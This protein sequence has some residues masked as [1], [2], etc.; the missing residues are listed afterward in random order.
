MSFDTNLPDQ[1]NALDT[2]GLPVPDVSPLLA[3]KGVVGVSNV[4]GS[5]SGSNAMSFV[6]DVDSNF[7]IPVDSTL[8]LWSGKGLPFGENL[9][10]DTTD[11]L[12]VDADSLDLLG[13]STGVSTGSFISDSTALLHDP[14][15]AFGR[16]LS[17]SPIVAEALAQ[18]E[19]R[20]AT[21]LSDDGAAQKLS[22]IFDQASVENV[23]R[24]LQNIAAGTDA[25]FPE[26]KFSSSESLKNLAGEYSHGAYIQET[27]VILI[28]DYFLY[29]QQALTSDF[30]VS[31]LLEE[32]GH[33]VDAQV[34]QQ[35][36]SGDE[37]ALLAAAAL[38]IS[39]SA[40]DLLTLGTEN[41]IATMMVDGVLRSVE[42][43]QVA[44]T[45]LNG[46]LYRTHR[47][48]DNNVYIQSSS[49]GKD[50]DDWQLVSSRG[51]KTE[52]APD[53][54]AHNGK[55]YISHTGLQD[56]IFVGSIDPGEVD[57]SGTVRVLNQKLG[58]ETPDAISL[59]KFGNKLY[60]FH[61]GSDDEIYYKS[62][63]QESWNRL[64]TPEGSTST[65]DA[66]AIEA[67][68]GKLYV[69]H[70]SAEGEMYFGTLSRSHRFSGWTKVNGS[71]EQAVAIASHKGRLYASHTGTDGQ[72]YNGVYT[73]QKRIAWKKQSRYTPGEASLESFKRKLIES[74]HSEL[75]HIYTFSS[76]GGGADKAAGIANSRWLKED[77][78]TDA[79][80]PVDP[81]PAD[82]LPVDPSPVDPSPV[83]P[84]PVDPLPVVVSP[85]AETQSEITRT[86]FSGTV[87]PN[88][89]VNLRNSPNL[90]DRSSR[91]E[92]K[93]KR[94]QFD[95]WTTGEAVTDLW[96]GK[97]DS[98]W[99]RVK[100]TDLW[101]P[102]GYI[103][104]NPG[105]SSPITNVPSMP[106][107][108]SVTL[109]SFS[110]TVGPNIGVNLRNSPN[111]QDRSSRNE[112][113]SKRLQFDAWT[114]G[115]AVTD[116]WTGKRDS[117]WFRVKGTDLW[118]PSGY[119]YGNPGNSNPVTTAP[120]TPAVGSVT[121]TNFSGT[122][123]PNIGV[124]L[125]NS[126]NLQDRSSRNEPKNK[127]LQFDAWTNGEAVTDLWTGKRDPRWFRVKGTDL[128]VPS[129]YIYGNPGSS[130]GS[131]ST[132]VTTTPTRT[133]Y[134]WDY[135]SNSGL[136]GL[137]QTRNN[138]FASKTPNFGSRVKLNLQE[139]VHK[140]LV[141]TWRAAGWSEA[142]N[143]LSHYLN[144]GN[145]GNLYSINLDKALSDS[146]AMYQVFKRQ[147]EG[148]ALAKV[149]QALAKGFTSGKVRSGW[150]VTG[151]SDI[152]LKDFDTNW[153]LAIG[154]FHHR[155]EA[156]WRALPNT[157]G[158]AVDF[159]IK[160]YLR[161]VYDFDGYQTE[162]AIGSHEL[163]KNGFA[164]AYKTTGESSDYKWRAYNGKLATL[165]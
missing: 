130:T 111:L 119:I 114:T 122:V 157:N 79:T 126:P 51:F 20:I 98:R 160:F 49:N 26:I 27:N 95:A 112:P 76:P 118:V 11:V 96:T 150:G 107:V 92:P 127:R 86:N 135:V 37:G 63:A 5:P 142:A 137:I 45:E 39:L 117:R 58:G 147:F 19:S 156:T 68:R 152:L 69:A 8:D 145:G 100:G 144:Q 17:Q 75:G 159:K 161:D 116:L 82:S 94:L 36:S 61:R 31:V 153:K 141:A 2:S 106:V 128:W 15:L 131:P 18:V 34:S 151:G 110:G 103:Y 89:G 134:G 121:L 83:D 13:G 25:N 93:S 57:G 74:H 42:Q 22:S 53:I 97:R 65:P 32:I 115:E 109:T 40:G 9:V 44:M 143:M 46:K 91:N 72:I 43:S 99:F 48:T 124:N 12:P 163:H 73:G 21:L 78:D 148:D 105:S 29:N 35:D 7:S 154:G 67:H 102:S 60:V 52:R 50:W 80:T 136:D 84:S 158:K 85:S 64:D 4:N 28:S 70:R 123:G 101:V 120:S 133:T 1:N 132:P 10:A 162:P 14:V 30:L 138:E 66:I 108:G 41:D 129:G 155:Y 38:G 77:V 140:A 104:G 88:I 23:M 3:G 164:R 87:G 16:E 62:I 24:S 90:Q 81:L 47:G 125:R 146:S 6:A 149:Q 55:L 59:K 56:Q 165:I 139:Q 113:K 54:E 33:Y 71:T